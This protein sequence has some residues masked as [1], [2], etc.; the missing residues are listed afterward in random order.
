M[1]DEYDLEK[2]H[3]LWVG[4]LHVDVTDED[5]RNNFNNA[6]SAKVCR[7]S[8]SNVSLGHAYVNF[9]ERADG[10]FILMICYFI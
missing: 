2:L 3:S 7:D 4:D 5:L 10:M 9:E 6:H 8:I 1:S